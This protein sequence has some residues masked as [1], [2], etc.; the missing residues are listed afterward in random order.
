ML[1]E[2]YLHVSMYVCM[3]GVGE[4]EGEWCGR[5]RRQCPRGRKWRNKQL[6]NQTNGNSRNVKF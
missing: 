6:L 5:P 1:T 4:W 3:G 2:S